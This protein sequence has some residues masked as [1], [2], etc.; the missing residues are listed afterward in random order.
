[1]KKKLHILPALILV[2]CL[3]SGSVFAALEHNVSRAYL[4][5]SDGTRL[6]SGTQL[7]SSENTLHGAQEHYLRYS[8]ERDVRPI[9]AYGSE[10]YGTS[11]MQQIA[12]KLSEDGLSMVAGINASFF[13]F[14]T[15][16]PYGLVVTDGIVR[17]ASTDMPSVGFYADGSAV[18]GNPELELT[19]RT[20]D[21][22]STQIFYNKR[23]TTKNGIGLY[24][25]D[26]DSKTKN[27]ISAYNLLLEPVRRDT[28]LPLNGTLEL[29]VAGYQEN[30]ASCSIPDGYYVLSIAED[31]IYPSA[32]EHMKQL[33]K[34]D[35]VSIVTSCTHEWEN[36][37]YAC[38]GNE[39]LVED[40]VACEEFTLDSE[41]KN[42]ARTAIGLTQDGTLVLYTVD[43]GESSYG[44]NLSELA[45]RMV[46]EGCVIALNLDGGGSTTLG[47]TYPGYSS[48]ATVNEPEDGALRACA[49]FIFLV[50]ETEPAE[51]AS[52]IFLYPYG[53]QAVLPGA[54][55]SMSVRGVDRHYFAAEISDDVVYDAI[56][57]SVSANG[58][59]TVNPDASGSVTVYA[60]TGNLETHVKLPVLDEITQI[61]LTKTDG[62]ASFAEATVGG[63]SSVK[64]TAQAFYYGAS[65]AAQNSSFRWSVS[66]N[67]G[68]IDQNG[69]FTAAETNEK[70]HGTITVSY[71]DVKTEAN[72]TVAPSDPFA[73][74]KTHWAKDYVN[75]LYF[76]GILTGSTGKDGKLYYRPNDSMTRQEFVVALMRFLDVDVAQYGAVELPFEDRAKISKWAQNA[77]KAAYKLGYVGGS[78]SGGKLYANPTD[79]ISRQEAMVILARS[80]K[81]SSESTAALEKFS[82]ASRIASWAKSALAAMVERGVISGSGGKLKP[83][84][85]VTRAEV[86][87]ML[88]VM[89]STAR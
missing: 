89:R 46:E 51:N 14:D 76:D 36:V 4:S 27:T 57:G 58:V 80:Q 43:G 25:R 37:L 79:T 19:M 12:K 11:T 44:M 5:L 85:D 86:A 59:L 41:K 40:G 26:Y 6:Y 9:V 73:D 83:T 82:D 65:V 63:G 17:T 71:G 22:S 69:V 66:G 54:K 1:M 84:G 64:L 18:I 28:G 81:L 33:R 39:L 24:S 45:D 20:S 8:V 67:I 55:L 30:T 13:D 10:I 7:I 16:I 72:V 62:G 77:L 87:K 68:T 48:G 35:R 53:T 2:L 75:E 47:A 32:L 88:S 60:S 50:R 49:N 52:S 70:I 78:S 3:L 38:S 15:G 34:G 42:A 21:G 29:E 61:R 56:G 23:L 74:M 31:S